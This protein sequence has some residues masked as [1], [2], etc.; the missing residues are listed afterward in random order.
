MQ[1]PA[2]VI[3]TL[4]LL[5]LWHIRATVLNGLSL[6]LLGAMLCTLVFGP[7][8]AWVPLSIVLVVAEATSGAS[9]WTLGLNASLLVLWPIALSTLISVVV[10]KLPANIFVFIFVGGFFGSAAVV[11]LTGWLLTLMLW[12]TQS[13]PWGPLLEDYG[14]YWMLVGFSEAWLTGMLLTVM[15]VYKPDA[16]RLFD[17]VRYID[18]A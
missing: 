6:H 8:L 4:A 10:R 11:V 2:L 18:N 12:L 1:W 16:V 17:A 5:V 3:A 7:R 13:I 14:M 9:C 15:V